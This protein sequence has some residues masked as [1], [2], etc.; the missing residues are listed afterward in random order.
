M[1]NNESKITIKL[2]ID[3]LK[4]ANRANNFAFEIKTIASINIIYI[5]I[6]L[7]KK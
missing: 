7:L 3:I 5:I 6:I 4:C 2:K 1:L